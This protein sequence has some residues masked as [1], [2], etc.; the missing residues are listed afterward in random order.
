ME[1]LLIIKG[2]SI[3]FDNEKSVRENINFKIYYE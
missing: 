3:N 2:F 1:K